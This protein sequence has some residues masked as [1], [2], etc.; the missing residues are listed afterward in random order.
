[1]MSGGDKERGD[2]YVPKDNK[3]RGKEECGGSDTSS[4]RNSKKNETKLLSRRRRKHRKQRKMGNRKSDDSEDEGEFIYV[5]RSMNRI[6]MAVP[7]EGTTPPPEWVVDRSISGKD[8]VVHR[9]AI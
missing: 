5:D 1:M 8:V 2:A 6:D 3:K 4:A 7:L 9:E